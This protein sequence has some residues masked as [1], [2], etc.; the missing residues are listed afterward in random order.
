MT[1]EEKV[2]NENLKRRERKKCNILAKNILS[3][4]PLSDFEFRYSLS[5][6]R[7]G[8]IKKP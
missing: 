6:F 5:I 1:F 7:M 2:K 4:P 8:A 3:T